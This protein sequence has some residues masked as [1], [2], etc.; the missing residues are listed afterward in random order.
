MI[1]GNI[2]MYKTKR[3]IGIIIAILDLLSDAE[4][5]KVKLIKIIDT[6]KENKKFNI[7]NSQIS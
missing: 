2:K 1:F 5:D 7:K 3:K 6:K 4:R